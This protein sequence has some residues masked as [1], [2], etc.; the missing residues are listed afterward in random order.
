MSE[1]KKRKVD[2]FIAGANWYQPNIQQSSTTTQSSTTPSTKTTVTVDS[3]TKTTTAEVST[4][5][6]DEVKKGGQA[7]YDKSM[8]DQGFAK[9]SKGEWVRNDSSLGSVL[10]MQKHNQEVERVNKAKALNAGLFNAI[11]TIGDMISAGTGGNVYKREKNT[12]AED[13]AKDT[14]ARRD[15]AVAAEAAAKEKDRAAML[16]AL[17]NA[18]AAHDKYLDLNGIKKSSQTTEG[19]Q[20]TRTTE[21]SGGKTT[22]RS[23][24]TKTPDPTHFTPIEVHSADGS[25]DTLY[26][27]KT[28]AQLYK[29][30]AWQELQRI[31]LSQNT[32]LARVL[33]EQGYTDSNGNL[34]P[35]L[36]DRIID[37]PKVYP[38]LPASVQQMNRELYKRSEVF[39]R[40]LNSSDFRNLP[41]DEQY[42]EM[43]R[44]N[45]QIYGTPYHAQPAQ[46]TY[47]AASTNIQG[48]PWDLVGAALGNAQR[49]NDD[50]GYDPNSNRTQSR[51]R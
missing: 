8:R 26:V 2:E 47:S 20:E 45:A 3:P 16:D 4:Y 30:K 41:L 46:R 21:N 13:A 19:Y 36:K 38:F 14:I 24:T 10:N 37:D 12:I 34:K 29:D 15:H 5:Y 44:I 9:N 35:S 28:M 27:D 42:A 51:L 22:G 48:Q 1:E 7:E 25:H 39:G 31:N 43:E 49:R 11:S 17:K 40:Y 50:E 32:E 23:T 6:S 33:E 18:R